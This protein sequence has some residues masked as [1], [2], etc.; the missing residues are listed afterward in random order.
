MLGTE[1]HVRRGVQFVTDTADNASFVHFVRD[2]LDHRPRRANDDCLQQL[3]W[4]YSRRELARCVVTLPRGRRGLRLL[5]ISSTQV[6]PG[7][8]CRSTLPP[9]G[10]VAS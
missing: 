1:Q 9:A 3:R 6:P 4:I 2:A 5:D 8:I 10:V 7:R